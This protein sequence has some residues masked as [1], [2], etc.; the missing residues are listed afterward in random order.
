[1][2]ACLYVWIFASLA[3]EWL[4]AF[5]SDKVFMSLFF[6]ILYSSSK[7]KGPPNGLQDINWLFSRNRRQTILIKL[8]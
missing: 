8:R 3:P 5:H 2:F 4:G 6:Y 7:N 1:M